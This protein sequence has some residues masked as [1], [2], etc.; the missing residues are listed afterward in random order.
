M[1]YWTLLDVTSISSGRTRF[2]KSARTNEIL[3]AVSK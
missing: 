1:A 3:V 2:A